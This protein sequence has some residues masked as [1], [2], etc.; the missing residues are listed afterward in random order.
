MSVFEFKEKGT[1]HDM[2]AIVPYS[3]NNANWNLC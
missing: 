3:E 2:I 1:G